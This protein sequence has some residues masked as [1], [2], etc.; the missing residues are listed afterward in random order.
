VVVNLAV[1]T[2]RA[3]EQIGSARRTLVIRTMLSDPCTVCCTFEDSGPGIKPKHLDHL[4]DGLFTTK[5]ARMGLGLAISRSIIEAHGGFIGADNKSA[6]GGARFSF[7]RR[8][9]TNRPGAG[10]ACAPK[11]E[12]GNITGFSNLEYSLIGKVATSQRSSTWPYPSRLDDLDYECVL[13]EMVFKAVAPTFAIEP[14]D[15]PIRNNGEIE[16]TT[17]L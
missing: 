14:V 4:F 1:N 9:C 5:N 12:I 10:V 2:I 15:A 3:M 7:N 13:A 17:N 8:S 6:L 16:P 11:D